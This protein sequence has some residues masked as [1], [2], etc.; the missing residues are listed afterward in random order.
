MTRT[1]ARI[2]VGLPSAL[3][4]LSGCNPP[5]APPEPSITVT[6]TLSGDDGAY[7]SMPSETLTLT[8]DTVG[9]TPR[10][11]YRDN[12]VIQDLQSLSLAVTASAGEPFE[13]EF[14]FL[15]L[16]RNTPRSDDII[17]DELTAAPAWMRRHLGDLAVMR[18]RRDVG[19]SLQQTSF[20]SF[21]PATM[22]PAGATWLGRIEDD[23]AVLPWIVT[24]DGGCNPVPTAQSFVAPAAGAGVDCFDLQTLGGMFMAQ[25]AVTMTEALAGANVGLP[26]AAGEHRMYIVPNY[27]FGPN[28]VPGFGFIYSVTINLVLGEVTADIPLGFHFVAVNAELPRLELFIDPLGGAPGVAPFASPDRITLTYQPGIINQVAASAIREMIVASFESFVVPPISFQGVEVPVEQAIVQLIGNVALRP[29]ITRPYPENFTVLAV[30][31]QRA[32]TET[33]V[34]NL[35]LSIPSAETSVR[36]GAAMGDGTNDLTGTRF[37]KTTAAGRVEIYTYLD[38]KGETLRVTTLEPIEQHTRFEL[39]L[40]E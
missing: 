12:G 40:M 17:D 10:L 22:R 5:V 1:G 38:E 8:H 34:P 16:S 24:E 4:C 21:P 26:I 28:D 32:T 33:T 27:P 31:E 9:E 7:T 13:E 6:A 30:P 18:V 19:L 23:D 20:D 2:L 3:L 15:S 14:I 35:I 11:E 36:S 37:V 39:V 29:S 25:I